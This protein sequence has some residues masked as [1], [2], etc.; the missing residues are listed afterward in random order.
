MLIK[1]KTK[2]GSVLLFRDRGLMQEIK[3]AENPKAS[4]VDD[5]PTKMIK[6]YVHIFP[7][8]YVEFS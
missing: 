5:I 6:E 8:F 3:V 4:Q 1:E 7:N 2:R